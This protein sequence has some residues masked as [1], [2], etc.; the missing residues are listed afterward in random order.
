MNRDN[1]YTIKNWG[2]GIGLGIASLLILW[3]SI[4]SDFDI[5]TRKLFGILIFQAPVVYLLVKTKS[6][7]AYCVTLL[8]YTNIFGFLSSAP[9]LNI[10]N[11]SIRNLYFHVP[12]WFA[13]II[14]LL[15]SVIYSIRYLSKGKLEDDIKAN[16]GVNIS[17][18]LGV[19]GLIT[20]MIWATFT[21]GK[22]W[23][24]D[25]KQLATLIGLLMYFAYI[26]L[27]GSF[28]DDMQRARISAIYNVFA[29]PTLIVLLYILPRMTPDSLHPGNG[30]NPAFGKYDL[31]DNMVLVF[32]PAI[33]AWTLLG[34]WISWIR[35]RTRI[36]LAK[37][38]EIL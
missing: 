10:V 30:G 18:L 6:W 17:I 9:R 14:I 7:R 8:L 19:L 27:R 11:E 4:N 32:Y 38:N 29:F 25:P 23:H 33:V 5:R 28:Q 37:K 1:R 26:I 3:L 2:I 36:L 16:E 15:V 13:M 31:D 20:G 34:V 22:P 24:G 12:M 35:I 21:W